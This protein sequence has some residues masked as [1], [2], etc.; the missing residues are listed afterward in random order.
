MAAASATI[1]RPSIPGFGIGKDRGL[2]DFDIRNVV[3]FSGGYALPFGKGKKFMNGASGITNAIAGRMEPELDRHASRRPAAD[4][5]LSRRA[6]TAGTGCYALKVPGQSQKLGLH[7]DANG[8][9]S[10]VSETLLPSRN[11][12]CSEAH[13]YTVT[14]IPRQSDRLRSADGFRCLWVAARSQTHGPGFHRLDFSAFKDFKI[15]ERF[16][17]QFRAEFFNIFNHPNFNAPNFG[18]NGVV[19][20]SGSANFLPGRQLDLRRNWFNARCS[21]RSAPDPVRVEAVF[22]VPVVP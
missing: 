14:P 20:I 4:A 1:A 11:P 16:T 22:L 7:I 17:A 2:A 19:A 5:H 10:L 8:Q 12:A 18:G 15:T 9:L 21:I 13:H 6:T 3:H